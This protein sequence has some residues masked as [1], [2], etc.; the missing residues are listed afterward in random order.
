MRF[1]KLQATGNDFILVDARD[2]ECNWASLAQ[3]MCRY[4]FGVGAD[5]LIL[6]QNSNVADLKTRI[7]NSDGSEAEACGNGLRCLT[8]YAIEKNVC[9]KTIL[10]IE[11]LSGI[12]QVKAHMSGNKVSRVEVNMG[13]PRF[14]PEQIPVNVKA[15]VIPMLN[16]PVMIGK[17]KLTLSL[18]SMG[19]PH[20]VNFLSIPVASFP[21]AKIGPKVERHPMFPQRTNFE[22]ARVLGKENIEARVW[23]RGVGETLACGSGACAIG[24]AAQLAGYVDKEVDIMFPGGTLTVFWD[25]AGEVLLSGPVE[26]V[27]TGEWRYN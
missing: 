14:E 13:M 16:H 25:G 10:S 11:S 1:S 20:A 8:K 2:M 22:I 23:E 27:F 9:G 5:G 7:F 3:A 6:M 4:H 17:R 21:L 18:L 24:V 19:N 26:E 12:R 15:D